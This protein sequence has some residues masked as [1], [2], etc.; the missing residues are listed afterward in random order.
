MS[1][2]ADL[3]ITNA[4]VYTMDAAHPRARAIAISD[5]RILATGEGD[6]IDALA[7]SGTRII[8]AGGRLVLPGFQDTHI[9]LMESGIAF[10]NGVDLAPA[11][12]IADLQKLLREQADKTR[13]ELWVLG[14]GWEPALFLGL[15]LDRHALDP[16]VDDRPVFLMA[17]DGHNAVINTAA[18]RELGLNAD[19]PNPPNGEIARDQSGEPTGMLH[20]DAIWEIHSR[21][22]AL[23]RQQRQAGTK[24]GAA[25]ANRHGITGVL[26]AMVSEDFMRTYTELDQAGELTLRVAATS[27]VFPHDSLD[28]A[29][30]RLKHIRETYRTDRVYMHSAK[31]FLD[32]VM[33]NGTA[34]MLEDYASGGNAPIMFDEPLLRQLMV[35]FDRERFQLHLHTIGDRAVRVALDGIEAA[36][37]ANGVWPALHQLAHI[38]CIHPD[39]IP[40]FRELETVAN[41][42][43]LWAC[44][45]EASKLALGRVGAQRGRYIYALNSVIETG[46]PYAISSDW[47]VSTLNPFEIMQVAVTRQHPD[48]A[49]DG[50]ALCDNECIDVETVV[51]GYTINAAAGAWRSHST[52]SLRPGKCADLIVLDQDIFNVSR[53]Q[54]GNTKVLLTLL[55]GEEVHRADDFDA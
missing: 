7:G 2:H 37:D 4:N 14:L 51:R 29:M 28:G 13:G 54:I 49:P 50:P 22:P 31:F 6:T 38:E 18:L 48:H 15:G 17:A 27:K 33:E 55:D 53:Y 8:D 26:D 41:W 1:S 5:G 46:A 43:P 36:R 23:S 25:H 9:H 47:F 24:F 20:E 35:A 16:V 39:D 11:K 3:I 34:A 40:R 42:Q 52:G 32:G 44:P 19:S 30:E 21:L 10:S 45:D 12:G